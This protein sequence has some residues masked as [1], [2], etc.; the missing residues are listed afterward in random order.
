MVKKVF[1]TILRCHSTM[2]KKTVKVRGR[3]GT[4]T[5]DISIPASITRKH[6]VERGDVFAIE[7]TEDDEGR[8]ILKYTR[9]YDGE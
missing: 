3:K 2:T 6:D 1:L 9:V 4:A 5:M 7:E 8:L